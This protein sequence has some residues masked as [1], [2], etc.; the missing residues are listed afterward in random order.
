[1]IHSLNSLKQQQLQQ[2]QQEQVQNDSFIHVNAPN[3]F[4]EMIHQNKSNIFLNFLLFKHENSD[5]FMKN[6]ITKQMFV[7]GEV[8]FGN[9]K[10]IKYDKI[11]KFF[12]YRYLLSDFGWINISPEEGNFFYELFYP[13]SSFF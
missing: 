7:E 13:L 12:H 4:F 9:V 11:P 10:M 2:Q 3:I 5:R 6:R 1:M 8:L